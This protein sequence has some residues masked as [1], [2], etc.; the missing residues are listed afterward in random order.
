MNR[1]VTIQ[2]AASRLGIS[3]QR[4][5]KLAAQ[6]RLRG[7]VRR[8]KSWTIPDPIELKP[9]RR[10]PDGSAGPKRPMKAGLYRQRRSHI[11]GAVVSIY[12]ARRAGLDDAGGAWAV[13]CEDHGEVVN[14][15]TL[16]AAK[17]VAPLVDWCGACCALLGED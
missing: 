9:G 8:G 1:E 16:R 3:E 10:G 4:V 7:A 2:E 14:V 17:A 15:G 12:D 11:T 5:R 13:G 6:G